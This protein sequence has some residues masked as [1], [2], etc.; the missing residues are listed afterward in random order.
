MR[1]LALIALL[2]SCASCSST[3]NVALDWRIPVHTVE[4]RAAWEEATGR[5]I[6]YRDGISS[7]FW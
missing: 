1:T 4:Q 6:Q 7:M 3:R 5:D 2:L